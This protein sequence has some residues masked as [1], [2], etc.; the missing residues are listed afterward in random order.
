MKIVLF[1]HGKMGKLIEQEAAKQ[2]ITILAIIERSTPRKDILKVLPD[3]DVC[4]DFSHSSVVMDHLHMCIHANRPLIIGTTGW[5]DKLDEARHLVE[6]SSIGCLYSPNFLVGIQ[7]F[8]QAAAYLASL[9]GSLKDYEAAGVE[10]HH[11]QKVDSPSGTAKAITKE[12]LP[13]LEHQPHFQFTSVRCGSMPG[14]HTLIFDSPWDTLTFTHE[15]R[16]RAGFA[17]GALK[18]AKWI[19]NKKGFYTCTSTAFK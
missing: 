2:G 15:T 4:I 18:A 14:T 8:Q 3:A 10:Y 11:N 6:S 1:G 19:Q 13:H 9:L 12:I 7:V 16:Q 5:E 17:Q